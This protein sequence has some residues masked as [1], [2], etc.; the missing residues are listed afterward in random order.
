MWGVF[1]VN[2]CLWWDRWC[3]VVCQLSVFVCAHMNANLRALHA[4]EACTAERSRFL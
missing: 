4:I 1:V 2:M 3:L